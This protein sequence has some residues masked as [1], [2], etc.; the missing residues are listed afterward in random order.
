MSMFSSA[1]HKV[2]TA[3]KLPPITLGNVIRAGVGAATG[4][5]SLAVGAVGS[6]VLDRVKDAF[7]RKVDNTVEQINNAQTASAVVEGVKTNSP[8]L[9]AGAALA[10][11]L[12]L[13]KR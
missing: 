11:Y 13:K 9:I 6:S 1:V 2:R 10:A 8:L 5:T 3:L 4:G 7:N 12:I